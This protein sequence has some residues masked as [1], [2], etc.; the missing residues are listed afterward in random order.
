M[1]LWVSNFKRLQLNF[2]AML[3]TAQQ[4]SDEITGGTS[5]PLVNV[6]VYSYLAQQKAE[7]KSKDSSPTMTM[8]FAS[9]QE[10]PVQERI[11]KKT[12]LSGIVRINC[13]RISY[14]LHCH[15]RH[16]VL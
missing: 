11:R 16:M 12:L 2:F 14:S 15:L 1:L 3:L 4:K 6:D 5:L 7:D 10:I 8:C 13:I 9:A